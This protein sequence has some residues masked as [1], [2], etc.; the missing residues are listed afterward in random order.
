MAD[1]RVNTPTEAFQYFHVSNGA[2]TELS[3]RQKSINQS[4]KDRKNQGEMEPFLKV[5]RGATRG[6]FF[7]LFQQEK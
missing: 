4:P 6:H 7:C 2:G 5:L 3:F 1:G